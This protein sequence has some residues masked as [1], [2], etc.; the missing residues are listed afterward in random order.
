LWIDEPKTGGRTRVRYTVWWPDSTVFSLPANST[1][2]K[3][4]FA[5]A[6][7]QSDRLPF[8]MLYSTYSRN[9]VPEP[10]TYEYFKR[11]R[12]SPLTQQSNFPLRVNA[13]ISLNYTPP[14]QVSDVVRGMAPGAVTVTPRTFT[15][16]DYFGRLEGVAGTFSGCQVGDWIV[17]PGSTARCTLQIKEIRSETVVYVDKSI[18]TLTGGGIPG[19]AATTISDVIVFRNLGLVGLFRLESQGGNQGFLQPLSGTFVPTSAVHPD[20]IVTGILPNGLSSFKPLRILKVDSGDFLPNFTTTSNKQIT[21][22]DYLSNGSMLPNNF[23]YTCAIYSSRGLEDLS[24]VE[25]CRGVYGREVD[26]TANASST[27]ITLTTNVG[28]ETGDL[29]NLMELIQSMVF[30][31]QTQSYHN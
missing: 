1:Y 19:T 3:K 9:Q 16:V 18:L 23:D 22:A 7:E 2:R 13:T 17:F 29:C 15:I 20:Y 6:I 14:N 11:N 25:Q 21:T 24:S 26:V 27:Q 30:A 8:S 28:V 4:R 5:F 12:A 10:Y 31:L